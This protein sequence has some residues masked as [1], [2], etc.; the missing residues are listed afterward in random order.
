M[1]FRF[2]ASLFEKLGKG[3]HEQNPVTAAE[4]L[5]KVRAEIQ[6]NPKAAIVN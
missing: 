1:I 6:T 3:T 5:N 2:L 4:I